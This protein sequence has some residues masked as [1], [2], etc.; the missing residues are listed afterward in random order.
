VPSIAA[1]QPVHVTKWIEAS[2]REL[3][4]PSVKQRLAAL[5]HLFD[6]LVNGQVVRRSARRIWCGGPGQQDQLTDGYDPVVLISRLTLN[7]AHLIGQ[8]KIPAAGDLLTGSAPDSFPTLGAPAWP[9]CRVAN[10]A[11][12]PCNCPT[13]PLQG[14]KNSAVIAFSIN[15][16]QAIDS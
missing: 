3:A 15:R 7:I 9:C 4:A 2:M 16:P 11:A 1:V 5:R 14:V 10:P 6:W 12:F 13:I 8:T